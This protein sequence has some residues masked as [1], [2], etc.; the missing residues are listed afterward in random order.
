MNGER[1][2]RFAELDERALPKVAGVLRGIG[3]AA[4]S[5]V[6]PRSVLGRVVGPWIRREPVIAISLLSVVLAAV[7]IATTGGDDHGAVRPSTQSVGPV[8]PSA[9]RLGP[10]PGASVP[11]YLAAAAGRRDG[12]QSLGASEHVDALVDLTAYISPLAIDTLL[13]AMPDVSVL[14]GF[15]RVPPPVEARVHVLVT[16]SRANLA[17]ELA[18]AQAAA[19]Q[20]AD[21]YKDEISQSLASPSTQLSDEIDAGAATAAAAR[22]DAS[23]LGS[24]CGCVFALIV[25]GPVSE[26][27]QLAGAASV[28][29]LDPAPI[30]T[31]IESLMVVP[32]EPQDTKKVSE[33]AYAGD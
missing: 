20:I 33:L 15:A 28:R 25:S 26:L 22:V 12:L 2:P 6:G 30:G 23:G 21:H 7:L 31:S 24:D 13:A 19:S 5:V 11:S 10:A 17:T 32:L 3:S 18:T 1:P 29:V 27:E 9:D 8:L 14:R 4:S 16:S